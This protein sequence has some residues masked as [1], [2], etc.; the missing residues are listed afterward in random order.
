[1]SVVPGRLWAMDDRAVLDFAEQYPIIDVRAERALFARRWSPIRYAQRLTWLVAQPSSLET[2]PQVV[3]RH[4]RLRAR[5]TR[6][7][8]GRS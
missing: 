4:E 8:L 1:M 2:H 6:A 7:V 3:R 5:S